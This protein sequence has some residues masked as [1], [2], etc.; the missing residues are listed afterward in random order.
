[1]RQR[2][3]HGRTVDYKSSPVFR[4][5]GPG[6]TKVLSKLVLPLLAA[7]LI[8]FTALPA[9]ADDAGMRAAAQLSAR[10]LPDDRDE[11][12]QLLTLVGPAAVIIV[13]TVLGLTITVRGLREDM[14]KRRVIYRRQGHDVYASDRVKRATSGTHHG[15]ANIIE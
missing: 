7:S 10:P 14:R 13:L 11:P 12:M 9:A 15:M 3:D 6:E 4:H 5:S 8:G 1:V 2:T